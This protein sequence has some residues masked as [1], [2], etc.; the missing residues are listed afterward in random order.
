MKP[1]FLQNRLRHENAS[2][3]F[4]VVFALA[5]TCCNSFGS[6]HPPPTLPIP[7]Q[8]NTASTFSAN[9]APP[10]AATLAQWWQQFNDPVLDTLVNDAIAA[11]RNLASARA[12]L[13]EARARRDFARGKLGPALGASASA[14]R[15]RSSTDAGRTTRSAYQT[16]FDASWE[17]DIFGGLRHGLEA[18]TSDLEAT[19]ERLRDTQVSLVA[20]VVE[21][22]VELRTAE[23]RLAIAEA[24]LSTRHETYSLAE[25]R[26]QAGLASEL[27]V[28]QAR[29]ELESA[30]ATLP[31]LQTEIAEAHNRLAVLLGRPP[32][33]IATLTE[34]VHQ[35]ESGQAIP[36]AGEDLAIGIPADALRQRPDVRGA[37]RELAAQAS[38]LG[39]AKA[40]RYPRFELSGRIGLEALTL[41]A[42][43][44][45][46]AAVRSLLG[47][48]TVPIFE[49][50]RIAANIE[51]QDAL[52]EQAELHYQAT[53]L[54]ALEDVENA[55][56]AALNTKERYSRLAAA[57]QSARTAFQLA[58]QRY[59]SG[60][61]DFVAVLDSQRTLHNLEDQSANSTSDLARAQ[62]QLYKALGGGW[63]SETAT[64]PAATSTTKEP[65]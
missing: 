36:V 15:G 63:T 8:W 57:T 25:W 12:K 47:K 39:V 24:S 58:E 20:E 23:Q 33:E 9:T 3:K 51:I 54:T 16:G 53:I 42:L 17:I 46:E 48:I 22:Y 6:S 30:G 11:N 26:A 4:C 31:T 14:S 18:A 29:T 65:E 35:K 19:H 10:D 2:Q 64:E 45:H 55:L 59:A 7:T 1:V 52:L 62:I 13:R 27:D 28:A 32:G 41:S 50:G 38:R 60:L 44:D 61:V 43:G 56:V 21:N 37:E 40:E 5:L 34:V 49:S